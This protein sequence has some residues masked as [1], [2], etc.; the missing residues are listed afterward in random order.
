MGVSSILEI[1][2]KFAKTKP[3]PQ[4]SVAFIAW[5]MEEQGL[6][7]SEYFAKHPIW[8]LNHI[9]GGINLDA[10]LPEGKARDMVVV[11]NGA[12]Q[13]EDILA[14]AL[15][16]QDRVISPDPE[17]EK[18]AFYRSDHLNLAKVGVPVLDPG[19]GYDMLNGGK[20]AGQA[21]RDEYRTKHYHQ[22]SDEW[23]ADWDLSGPLADIQVLYQVGN[24]LANSNAWPNWFAGNEFRP[25]RDKTM[26]GK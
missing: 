23:Q 10:N 6:L 22:P 7:G 19:G 17:P 16:T 13:L 24:E 20:V 14:K 25:A 11:G 3:A 4:R 12:S 9:V 8:P 15:K 26:A 2:E 18:G 5:T 21:L 1:A